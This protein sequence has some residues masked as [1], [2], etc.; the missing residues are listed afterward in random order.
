L[1]ET[2]PKEDGAFPCGPTLGS[3]MVYASGVGTSDLEFPPGVAAK[4]EAGTQLLLN[5]HLFNTTATEMTGDS[6]TLVRTVPAASVTQEAAFILPGQ[7]NI[8]LP[9]NTQTTIKGQCTYSGDA[10]L[11][12][13][14]PHMHKLGVHSLITYQGAVTKTLH[15]APYKF[16]EQTNYMIAPLAVKTGDML[17]FECSYLN[18]T[19]NTV[20]FGDSSNQEMCFI[21]IYQYPLG[22][23]CK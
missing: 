21:G 23:K 17:R 14:W 11:F 1:R 3:N 16:G 19:P 8:L 12:A 20:T 6:G 22:P 15:D 7:N 10:T 9:P 2:A 13:V 18:N 4:I 5:L